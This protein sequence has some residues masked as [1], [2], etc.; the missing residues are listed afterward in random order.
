MLTRCVSEVALKP[1]VS[2]TLQEIQEQALQLTV[3]FAHKVV[4]VD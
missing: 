4:A 1:A 3:V 2:A